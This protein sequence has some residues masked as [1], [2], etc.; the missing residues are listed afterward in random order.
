MLHFTQLQSLLSS[1][2]VVI[3]STRIARNT[4]IQLPYLQGIN[5]ICEIRV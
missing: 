3:I 5:T 4:Q 2:K 1:E